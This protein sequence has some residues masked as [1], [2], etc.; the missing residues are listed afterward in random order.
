MKEK[1]SL[2]TDY[3][4]DHG[5]IFKKFVQIGV[6]RGRMILVLLLVFAAAMLFGAR[7]VRAQAGV[8][9]VSN[10]AY[11]FGEHVT[12]G[13]QVRS[14]SPVQQAFIF[15][16]DDS[17]GRPI[18]LNV[19]GYA[20]Y[21]LAAS[22]MILRPFAF[23]RWHYQFILAD[24]STIQSENF[25]VRYDDN[26][27]EWQKLESGAVRM[28]WAQGDAAFGQSLLNTALTGLQAIN[29]IV[30]PDLSQPVDIYVYASQNDLPTNLSLSGETW[31]AGHANPA[32]GVI[33]VVVEPG[34]N[35]NILMEQRI[36]HELL[37]V[38]SYRHIG[39]G[40]SNLPAWLREGMAMQAELYPNSEY[41][42]VLMESSARD[43]V[44]PIK[45]LCASFSPN[46]AEAFLAYAEARSFTN[47]LRG[48][49]GSDGLLN[50][51][52]I[53][54]TGV[55]CERG[56]ER[57][58]GISLAKLEMDWRT[59]VLGQNTLGSTLENLAPYLVLLCVVIF[60]PL[61]GII[62]SMRMKGKRNEPETYA[63][64]G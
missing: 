48:L 22:Q 49:Y 13:V 35:Q 18:Q 37:H 24:G 41:D 27:F 9:I 23:V 29:E 59:S 20:E 32:L 40:Y 21:R 26:R 7:Q 55:D 11:L 50:L 8:E 4:D 14:P 56:V 30:P 43:E 19:D 42:R 51:A 53:H 6:I 12:F 57:A 33:A 28:M 61:L 47:Y 60:A 31:L 34:S 1:N 63:R 15:I 46:S 16:Q 2:A 5:S 3:T 10:A 38:M 39:A 36:P 17:Q 52:S 64:R 25:F 44:I 62:N 58:F 45:D 54:A